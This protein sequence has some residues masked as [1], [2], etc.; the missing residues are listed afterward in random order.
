MNE[1]SFRRALCSTLGITALVGLP[2]ASAATP[3]TP[4]ALFA[5]VADLSA[6]IKAL[7]SAL[8]RLKAATPSPVTASATNTNVDARVRLI[9]RRLEVNAEEVAA[10]RAKVQA[11]SVSEKGLAVTSPDGNY[12]LKLCGSIQTDARFLLDDESQSTADSFLMRR[13]RPISEGT[14]AK[15]FYY[16]VMPDFAGASVTLQDAYAGWRQYPLAKVAVG[17]MKKPLGLESL[18]S[19]SDLPFVERGITNNLVP[20]R[21]IGLQVSGELLNGKLSYQTGVF[22]GDPDGEN[23]TALD[24]RDDKDFVGR[25]IMQPFLDAYGPLQGLGFGISGTYGSELGAANSPNLGAYRTPAQVRFLKYRATSS[26][27][28]VVDVKGKETSITL[29]PSLETTAVADGDRYRFSPQ[30]FFYWRQFGLSGDYVESTQSVS[31]ADHNAP[32][33]NAAW[34]VSAFLVLTGE[35]AKAT[36][37]TTRPDSTA[38]VAARS[39][40]RLIGIPNARC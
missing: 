37:T 8:A 34:Q 28:T 35:D 2:A 7:E 26:A 29:S 17:K 24:S 11:V 1:L 25:I 16:R 20:N 39:A 32:V 13:V 14:V 31:F 10:S 38:V 23:V 33:T 40:H 21:D 36:L 22:D 12:E 6:R 18:A 27:V 5:Q 15:Q 19:G 4:E 3:P 9:E 30:G